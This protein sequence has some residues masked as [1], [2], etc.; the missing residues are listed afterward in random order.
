MKKYSFLVVALHFKI[1]VRVILLI[2]TTFGSVLVALEVYEKITKSKMVDVR[3]PTL[4]N[5]T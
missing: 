4:E 2:L 3:W 5:M 1:T